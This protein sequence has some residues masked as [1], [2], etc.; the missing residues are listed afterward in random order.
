[1]KMLNYFRWYYAMQEM[2]PYGYCDN[3]AGPCSNGPIEAI[4]YGIDVQVCTADC[5]AKLYAVWGNDYSLMALWGMGPGRKILERIPAS[6]KIVAILA[7][8]MTYVA[9]FYLFS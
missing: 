4:V 8:A 1:M 5:L 7:V 3:C 9:S 6:S 2:E